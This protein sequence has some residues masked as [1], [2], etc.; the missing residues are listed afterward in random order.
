E[1]Q[2][3]HPVEYPPVAVADR[4]QA[5]HTGI[6]PGV[7]LGQADPDDLLAATDPRHPLLG[8]LRYR[9]AGEDLADQGTD[10]LQVRDVDVAAGDLLGDDPG[11]Q[12]V[13][14]LAAEL[15][16]QLRSDQAEPAKL[17]AQLRLDP[18]AP[19]TP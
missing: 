7:R 10:H 15:G 18:S 17:A 1:R 6:R 11:G 2:R 3:L 12:P 4:G 9:V 13:L 14:A 8:Q 16:R 5:R 19:L